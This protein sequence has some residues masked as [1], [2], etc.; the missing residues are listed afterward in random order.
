MAAAISE[1][2]EAL[3]ERQAAE[4]AIRAENDRLA[5]EFVRLKG[6]GLIVDLVPVDQITSEKLTRDR[7]AA[8]D[9]E[10]DELKAS[11][12]A[13][14][15]SNPI[16]IEVDGEGY[17]LVQGFRRLS[18]YQEL[19][20]ETGDEKYAR[21]PAGLIASGEGIEALYRRM[22]DENLIRRDISF[23]EMAALARAYAADPET[24]VADSDAAVALLYASAGRQKR[25]YIRHFVTLLDHIGDALRFPEAIP[26]ALGLSLERALSADSEYSARVKAELIRLA[27]ETAEEEIIYLRSML[28]AATPEKKGGAGRKSKSKTTLQLDVPAGTVRCAAHD[29]RLE[30]RCDVDF[31]AAEKDRLERALRAFF[32]ALKEG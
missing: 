28:E 10:I 30:M 32:D 23:A 5:E 4:A 13:I 27:A 16:R 18:A 1:N 15:L 25:S 31:S 14:G 26:R 12:A 9:P 8:R 17:H 11:I 6:Q 19:F 29:G 21:I 20:A 24:E 22:V 2:A 7:S 3:R